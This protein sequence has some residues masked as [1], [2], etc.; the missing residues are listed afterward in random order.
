MGLDASAH[1]WQ[2]QQA[3]VVPAPVVGLAVGALV[4]VEAGHQGVAG[5]AGVRGLG[6]DREV[7]PGQTR[8]A[9]AWGMEIKVLG[10]NALY[11]TGRG[12][13]RL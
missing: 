8:Q 4:G 12:K 7:V 5:E 2:V 13:L 9:W 3:A 1:L 11:Q 10:F 6:V